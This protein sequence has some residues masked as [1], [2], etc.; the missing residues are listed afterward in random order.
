[1]LGSAIYG[2]F[3]FAY[4]L[5][6]HTWFLEIILFAR[7]YVF[8]PV[9]PPLRALITSGM[10]WCDIGHVWLVKQVLRLFSI[11]PSINWK[12]LALVTQGAM[13]AKQRCQSWCHTSHRRRRINYLA[14]ATRWSA[15]VIKVSGWMHSDDFKRRQDFSFTVIIWA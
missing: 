4:R 8:L 11:L 1:M 9:C 12:G 7:R 3:C 14:V 10:I 15:T 6:N 13:H 2:S 5:L